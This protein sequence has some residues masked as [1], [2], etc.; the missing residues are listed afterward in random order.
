MALLREYRSCGEPVVPGTNDN[1][2]C[3][4]H[5]SSFNSGWIGGKLTWVDRPALQRVR[6]ALS[7]DL[8]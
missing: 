5:E 2:V 7:L 6:S 3:L 8:M 1:C 4:C